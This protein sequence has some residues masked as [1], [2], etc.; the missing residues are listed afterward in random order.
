MQALMAGEV[1]DPTTLVYRASEVDALFASRPIHAQAGEREAL[2]AAW[3]PTPTDSQ[4]G[5][6]LVSMGDDRWR[7]MTDEEARNHDARAALASRA[8]AQAPAEPAFTYTVAGYVNGY[9]NIIT[10]RPINS[11]DRA[12]YFR[13][14]LDPAINALRS[15]GVPA[16]DQQS[17]ES[18]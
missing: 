15:V 3:P 6:P 8:A 5:R 12:V 18:K 16:A 2:T 17:E 10:D 7:T 9:R 11:T 14:A 4:T 13:L 1:L